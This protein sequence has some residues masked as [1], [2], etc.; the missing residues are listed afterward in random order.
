MHISAST[1]LLF[2]LSKLSISVSFHSALIATRN[3]RK[4]RAASEF[5]LHFWFC[6]PSITHRD[7]SFRVESSCLDFFEDFSL[8]GLIKSGLECLD[9]PS[10]GLTR[11]ALHLQDVGLVVSAEDDSRGE[12]WNK[13]NDIGESAQDLR[14]YALPKHQSILFIFI[15]SLEANSLF[16]DL[17]VAVYPHSPIVKAVLFAQ[18]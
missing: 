2:N 12:D 6:A 18:V 3:S 16:V 9:P 13:I 14:T 10:G 5:Y 4:C 7:S 1:S 17:S 8:P 11:G 15:P